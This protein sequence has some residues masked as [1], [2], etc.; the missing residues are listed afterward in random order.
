MIVTLRALINAVHVRELTNLPQMGVRY[1]FLEA[2]LSNIFKT[3]FCKLRQVA[4]SS[5]DQLIKPK[6]RGPRANV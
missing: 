2:L 6:C 3:N 1:L 5:I 4:D